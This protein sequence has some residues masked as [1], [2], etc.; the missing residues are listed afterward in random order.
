MDR[1]ITSYREVKA[2]YYRRTGI[3]EI[4]HTVVLKREIYDKSP[5]VAI[6]PY[7]AFVE[8]KAAA[9]VEMRRAPG[10]LVCVL[11]W[12]EDNLNEVE[13]IMGPDPF[14]YGLGVQ[15][16]NVVDTFELYAFEQGLTPRLFTVEDLFAPETHN[17]IF[18]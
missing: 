12:L 2:D 4:M 6:N 13:R 18:N 16:R 9:I 8:A 10:S 17:A 7:N 15:N 1:L 11:P 3:F 14:V 5:W